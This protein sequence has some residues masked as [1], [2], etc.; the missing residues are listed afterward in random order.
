MTMLA[1]LAILLGGVL[2]LRF[3]ILILLPVMGIGLPVILAFEFTRA[4][5]LFHVVLAAVLTV[6][7]LQIGYVLGAI[8]SQFMPGRKDERPTPSLSESLR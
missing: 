8:G 6:V 3:R 4:D 1:T 7:G 5:G 2:G